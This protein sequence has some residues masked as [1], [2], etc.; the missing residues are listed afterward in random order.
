MA[1]YYDILGVSKNATKE[2]VK[3]AYRKLAHRYHPDNKTTGNEKKFKEINEAYQTLR[4]DKKRAEYD[5]YGRT[6]D[7]GTGGGRYG[8]EGVD[9]ND[10]AGAGPGFEFDFGDIF[11]NFFS[12]GT[13]KQRVRRGGDIVVDMEVSFEE[14]IFGAERKLFLSKT[15]LCDACKG[16]GA[17]EGSDLEKCGACH[18]SGRIHESRRSVFGTITALK[19]CAKCSGRGS[20]P[21][22]KC[23]VCGG[24]GVL[25][26]SEEIVVKIPSGIRDGEVISMLGMGE[27]VSN[28]ASGDLY[29]KINVKKHPVFRREENNIAMDMDIKISEAILGGEKEIVTLDGPIKLKIPAGIDSGEILRARDKGVPIGGHGFNRKGRGDLMI[30]ILVRT[31]KK[32][33]KKAKELLE[34]MREEGI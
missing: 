16:M 27:A 1:D 24:R 15:S 9:F 12:G 20:V 6:F 34:Q 5:V 7:G 8:F 4:E 29:V 33:S 18:G 23:S 13:R 10:F 17:G 28:G 11:E 19:E 21:S 25:K 30:K 26:K 2:E 32:I 31:P 3:K 14:S 22:K